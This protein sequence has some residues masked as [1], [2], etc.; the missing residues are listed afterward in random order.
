MSRERPSQ[1][2]GGVLARHPSRA[3]KACRSRACSAGGPPVC[4]LAPRSSFMQFRIDGR[5]AMVPAL[6][7]TSH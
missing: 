1:A 7:H 3:A 4:I 5:P 6:K 2:G